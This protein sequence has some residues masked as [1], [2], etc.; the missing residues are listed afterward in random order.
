MRKFG[1]MTL[2]GILALSVAGSVYAQD[3]TPE[4][5]PEGMDNMQMDDAQAMTGTAHVRI[6]YVV[7]DGP[8]VDVYVNTEGLDQLVSPDMINEGLGVLI[9][10]SEPTSITDF[11][12]APAGTFEV[13]ITAAGDVQP[14][15]GPLSVSL[16]E[17]DFITVVVAGTVANNT[18]NVYTL[19]EDFT[20][21]TEGGAVVTVVNAVENGVPVDIQ[22]ADGTA[23]FTGVAPLGG[24]MMGM[25]GDAMVGDMAA[26]ADPMMPTQD[27][28]M[29]TQD[30]AMATVDPAMGGDTGMTGDMGMAGT[31][32]VMAA[33]TVYV[34]AEFVGTTYDIRVI[35]PADGGELYAQDGIEIAANNAYLIV[36]YSPDGSAVEI[37]SIFAD[38][39]GFDLMAGMAG[40]GDSTTG[41]EG[42]MMAT[43]DPMMATEEATPAG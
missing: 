28:M 35:N 42:D 5:S 1:R 14:V 29:A 27:P 9:A 34:P 13:T 15:F 33:N 8:A 3:A 32:Q 43:E 10:T 31:S 2:V 37:Q 12:G 4:A 41:T 19:S 22:T 16:V 24:S 40:M 21:Y 7:P 17:G 20:G 36:A 25:E 30:P 26:T 39:T 11:L 38:L 18:V 23:I 6:A